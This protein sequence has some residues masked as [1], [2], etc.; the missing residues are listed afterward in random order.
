MVGEPGVELDLAA[1]GEVREAAGESQPG[2][3]CPP[4]LV[5]VAAL[6]VRVGFDGRDLRCL[7]ADLVCGG[8][9]TDRQQQSGSDPIRVADH[10]FQGPGAA[11]GAADD[12]GDLGD[13]QRGQR[14]DVRLHLV[15]YR[16][17]R[18]S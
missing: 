17:Q 12:G 15:T 4:R 14:R 7:R 11:H 6:P 5:V 13:A 10:P 2:V 18:K 9:R 16:D 1:V 8:T 3:W